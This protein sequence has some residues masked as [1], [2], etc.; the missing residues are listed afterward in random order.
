MI[1]TS[2]ISK[3]ISYCV[4]NLNLGSIKQADEYYYHSLPQCVI[5][6][7]FSIGVRYTGVQKTV[8]NYCDYF[9][10]ILFSRERAT[11]AE[12]ISVSQFLNWIQEFSPEELA[13]KV[14][15]N[16]QRTSTRNGILKAEAV[17]LF[18]EV[19]AIQ[20]VDYFQDVPRII[21]DVQFEH[22]I[23]QIPGQKSGLS[24]RYFYMLAGSDDFVKP[25]RMIRRFLNDAIHRELSIQ[26]CQETL[27]SACNIL[28][29]DYP[30]IT[31]RLLDHQI[32]LYQRR[33]SLL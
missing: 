7:V 14:F 21:G 10:V 23:T 8:S 16:R 2:D 24:T 3:I 31:P 13:V 25:D 1:T 4:S 5:D 9:G 26:E 19:L 32:W 11:K 12:Q 20:R 33:K 17:R 18:A 22:A 29:K 30:A 28:Q 15:N 6:S 27:I